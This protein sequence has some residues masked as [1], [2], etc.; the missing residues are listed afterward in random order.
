MILTCEPVCRGFEHSFVNAAMLSVIAE[1]FPMH[2][3]LFLADQG[4]IGFIQSDPDIRSRAG[5]SFEPLALPA[6]KASD[7]ERFE[8]EFATVTRLFIRADQQKASLLFFT[9]VSD[10]TLRAIK[11]VMVKF[12]GIKCVAVMHGVLVSV[13]KRPSVFPWKNRNTFRTW[14]LN[15]NSPQL[16]YILMGG[17]IESELVV[18]SPEMSPYVISIDLPYRFSEPNPLEPFS[19][20]TVTFGSLGVIR[21]AKGSHVFL[22]LAKQV[23]ASNYSWTPRFICIG[24]VVDKDL[25]KYLGKEVISPSPDSPLSAGD[26]SFHA[27]QIDYAVFLHKP[28]IYTLSASG[29]LFDAFS[30]LKPIIAL[31]NP[32]VDHY[33]RKMGNIGYLCDSYQEVKST[34]ECILSNPPVEEYRIQRNALLSG[35]EDLL[36]P[37]IAATLRKKLTGRGI[38]S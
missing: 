7:A 25:R 24:P 29:V 8:H 30:Y 6:R 19:N 16:T 14:F 33:F 38:L 3:L 22:R 4:H 10:E 28:E 27:R 21:K 9:C 23:S 5:L 11:Q 17:S 34:I 12:P 31:R 32:L 1:A 26:F 20:R 13:L 37:A 35:R 2:D 15:Q 18:R 36:I